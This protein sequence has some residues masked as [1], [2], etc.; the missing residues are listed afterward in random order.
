MFLFEGRSYDTLVIKRKPIE[1]GYKIWVL[2]QLGYFLSWCFYRKSTIK[3][4]SL[5]SKL[6]P[7]KIPQ[8]RALGENNNS[9]IVAYLMEYI[10]QAGYIIY[11]D[12]LFTN[13]KLL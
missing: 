7:Y 8:P 3:G 13:I 5:C 1:K 9:A 10:P 4:K 12:N 11:L 2:A 6:G